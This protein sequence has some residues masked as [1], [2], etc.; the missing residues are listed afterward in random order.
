MSPYKTLEKL[1]GGQASQ[2]YH[3]HSAIIEITRSEV[4][5]FLSVTLFKKKRERERE[6]DRETERERERKKNIIHIQIC[7]VF[8]FVFFSFFF[9]MM[10]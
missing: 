7:W 10:H 4:H 3:Y 8:L 1:K 6:R 5:E 9:S 2:S